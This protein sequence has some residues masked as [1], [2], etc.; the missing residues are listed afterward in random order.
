MQ[1]HHGLSPLVFRDVELRVKIQESRT[2]WKF[3]NMRGNAPG[4]C[5]LLK[6]YHRSDWDAPGRCLL[7]NGSDTQRSRIKVLMSSHLWLGE[8]KG[9]IL[10]MSAAQMSI[11]F[12]NA[13]S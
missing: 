13:D 9:L 4:R 3:P 11:L 6:S 8:Y 1:E 7:L 5:L 10:V 2:K 12:I